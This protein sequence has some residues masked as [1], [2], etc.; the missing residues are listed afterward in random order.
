MPTTCPTRTHSEI[1]HDATPYTEESTHAEMV[2]ADSTPFAED[3]EKQNR[4]EERAVY[5]KSQKLGRIGIAFCVSLTKE[6]QKLGKVLRRFVILSLKQNC[7]TLKKSI[8]LPKWA[9]VS[10]MT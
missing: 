6:A 8:W 5:A 1:A 3:G 2:S 4:V 10:G 9:F 7:S